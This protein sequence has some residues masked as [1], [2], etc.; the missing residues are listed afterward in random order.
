V[1]GEVVIAGLD[2]GSTKVCACLAERRNGGNLEI[3]GIGVAP[4]TGM[5]KG[6]VVNIEATL[7]AI[8]QAVDAAEMMS[9]SEVSSLWTGIGGEQIKGINS[10]GVVS[11]AGRNKDLHEISGEDVDRVLES[12]RAIVLPLDQKILEVIP[13]TYLVDHQAGIRNPVDMIGV[14]LEAEVHIITCPLTSAQNLIKC[15]NR[16]GYKVPGLILQSLA[17]GR[18]V[19]T[20]E[21]KEIGVAVVDLGGGTTDL[22]VYVEGAPYFTSTIP[23]GGSQ[24]T[25]DIAIMM[26]LPFETAEK[27]KREQACCWEPLVDPAES[28]LVPGM[29]GRGPQPIPRVHI[30][31]IV[32]P[33]MTEIFAKVKE[34]LDKHNITGQLS[35]GVVLAGGGANIAGAAELAGNVFRL[36]VRVGLPLL[37]GGLEKDYRRPE[38]ATAVGLALEGD[39][40]F[41]GGVD[42]RESEP[43]R[44]RQASVFTRLARW[45]REE[46]F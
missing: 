27:V 2:I 40:R 21:E 38:F 17:S 29:G 31:Q 42:I 44:E 3:T 39:I 24:V 12:A 34:E 10:R 33:R 32:Q 6:V 7:R 36:P 1:A 8:A 25:G 18:A 46:F 4:S 20:D 28:V 14:R 26:N 9:G 35:G 15:V 22:I 41:G 19:L 23:L 45:V 43:A 30:Q 16:A 37:P 11:V 5:K 13:Q